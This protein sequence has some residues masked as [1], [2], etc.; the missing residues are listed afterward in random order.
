MPKNEANT[1]VPMLYCSAA[2]M[3]LQFACPRSPSLLGSCVSTGTAS[4]PR[5][6]MAREILG[7]TTQKQ[8][9]KAGCYFCMETY[10][11]LDENLGFLLFCF[12]YCI[13]TK[14]FFLVLFELFFS[15]FREIK[16]RIKQPALLLD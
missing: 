5:C 14:D 11:L 10:S 7:C 6:P 1:S 8:E 16:K 13:L 9:Y 2:P 15:F 3:E 4:P 12:A